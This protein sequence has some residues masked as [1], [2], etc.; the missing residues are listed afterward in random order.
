MVTEYVWP[1]EKMASKEL[2][3]LVILLS[4]LLVVQQIN[5]AIMMEYRRLHDQRQLLLTQVMDTARRKPPRK[6]RKQRR[7]WIRPGRTSLWWDN[8]LNGVMLE[9]E[10]KENFRMSRVSFFQFGC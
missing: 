9:E 8:F 10:W 1:S 3:V 6:E 4:C 2:V 7:F 5:Q